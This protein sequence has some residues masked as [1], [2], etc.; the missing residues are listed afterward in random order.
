MSIVHR[1]LCW[2]FDTVEA[3]LDR[4]FGQAW[5]P[6]RHLGALGFFMYWIVAISGIY[7]YI[8]FD[9]GITAA[10]ASIEYMTHDQWYLA[11]IMRSLHRYASDG[12]VLF[13]VIHLA[14]EFARDRYRGA[15]WFSWVTGVPVIA[16]VFVCGITGYWLVWDQ[17]AQYVAVSTT[18]WLD[19]LPIFGTPIAGNFL[20]PE[21]L[22]DRFFTLMIFIHIAAPLILLLVLWIHLN[23]V[24]RPRIHPPRGL[25]IGIFAMLIAVSLVQ[26]ALSHAPANLATVVATVN[27]DWFYLGFYPLVDIFS[28]GAVWAALA[29]GGITFVLIPWMPPLRRLPVAKVHLDHCNGCV[30]CADD[31]PYGAVTMQGRTDGAKFDLEAVVN[32]SLCVSCGICVGACPSSTPF[33]RRRE[34]ATGIDLPHFSL[35]DMRAAVDAACEELSGT[36]RVVVIGCQNTLKPS[37]RGDSSTGFVSLP[38]TGMLPPAFVDYIVN[39]GLADGV[40]IAGCAEGD[41]QNR[42]GNTW[43][44]ARV[45]RAR[46]PMLRARV[47]RERIERIWLGRGDHAALLRR[48]KVF[49]RR[50]G[51][52]PKTPRTPPQA[53]PSRELE[54]VGDG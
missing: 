52:L 9:T 10:Y 21:T 37:D 47:P 26:P 45:E 43:T 54:G 38:C 48:I 36:E 19:W 32:P 15:R 16:L 1:S 12:M 23:R 6:M 8:F 22:D 34:L 44:D 24:S 49:A 25:A 28:S 11:G 17:L 53:A 7:L 30:R 50:V 13:M 31:C 20:T 5:N 35:A 18:E 3:L 2:C 33:R 4:P 42:F 41:C 40:V 46:D 29:C 51:A 14:R 39:R 27:L